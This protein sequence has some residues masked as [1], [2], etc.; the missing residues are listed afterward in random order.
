MYLLKKKH[1]FLFFLKKMSY[2]IRI[3]IYFHFIESNYR[4]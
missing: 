3:N 2:Q 1:V 4:A